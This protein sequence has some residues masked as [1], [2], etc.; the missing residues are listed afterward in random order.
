MHHRLM[1]DTCRIVPTLEEPP[2]HFQPKKN[3]HGSIGRQPGNIGFPARSIHVDLS[4]GCRQKHGCPSNDIFSTEL[5][6]PD[7]YQRNYTKYC[8]T[9]LPQILYRHKYRASRVTEHLVTRS[10]SADVPSRLC[11]N[12][13]NIGHTR[14][15]FDDLGISAQIDP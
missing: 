14:S 3:L 10:D 6:T 5:H 12:D 8:S 4:N 13:A 11:R 15:P 2:D 9:E 7:I 1:G